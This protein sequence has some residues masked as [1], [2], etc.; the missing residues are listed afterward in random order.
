[1]QTKFNDDWLEDKQFSVWIGK[2]PNSDQRARCILC[3]VNFELGNMGV[4]ALISH[5]Q[6]KKT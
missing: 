5:A 3:G 2:D 4:R 1:M 6:G